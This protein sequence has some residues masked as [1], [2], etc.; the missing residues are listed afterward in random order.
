MKTLLLSSSI[1]LALAGSAHSEPTHQVQVLGSAVIVTASNKENIPYNF[2]ITYQVIYD[3]YGETKTINVNQA[4][5]IE[6][7]TTKEINRTAGYMTNARLGAPVNIQ[8]FPM[9]KK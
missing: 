7:N 5:S 9:P 1:A 2:Q 8:W 4:G 6:P 3:S